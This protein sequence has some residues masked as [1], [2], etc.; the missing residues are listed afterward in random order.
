MVRSSDLVLAAAGA[1]FIVTWLGAGSAAGD[2]FAAKGDRLVPRSASAPAKTT[3]QVVDVIGLDAAIIVLRDEEGRELFRADAHLGTTLVARNADLPILK[4]GLT[5]EERLP[6]PAP[7]SRRTMPISP[8][9]RDPMLGCEG[10]VSPLANQAASR[11][12]GRCLAGLDGFGDGPL[13]K[14]S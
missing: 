5:S 13:S 12:A 4:V 3:P 6:P 7:E 1:A 10:S 9:N 2:G 11:R 8:E 14:R